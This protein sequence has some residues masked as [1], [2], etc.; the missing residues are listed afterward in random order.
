MK[1][2]F[3]LF[4]F[5]PS[6]WHQGAAGDV[7]PVLPPPVKVCAR[8]PRKPAVAPPAAAAQ[9]GPAGAA[10]QVTRPVVPTRVFRQ[11]IKE[12]TASDGGGGAASSGGSDSDDDDDDDGAMAFGASPTSLLTPQLFV[13]IVLDPA[14]HS[15]DQQLQVLRELQSLLMVAESKRP[16][17]SE[18]EAQSL[19]VGASQTAAAASE[20]WYV[21]LCPY[22]SCFRCMFCFSSCHSGENM[23]WNEWAQA[24]RWCGPPCAAAATLR[25]S[26][27]SLPGH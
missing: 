4:W 16:K 18:A 8:R 26:P 1:N 12:E 10:A 7:V 14:K 9:T 5:P 3:F 24:G 25:V 27:T 11:K 21:I 20:S 19:L 22:T 2:I 23:P 15:E 13:S 17:M 6:L